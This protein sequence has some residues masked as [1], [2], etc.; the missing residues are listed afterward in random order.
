[1][2][3]VVVVMVMVVILLPSVVQRTDRLTATFQSVACNDVNST[4]DD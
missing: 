3:V 4:S 2:V 1:M